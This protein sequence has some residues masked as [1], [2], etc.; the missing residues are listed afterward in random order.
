MKMVNLYEAK[1]HLS[2]L[3]AEIEAGEERIT[4]C[5]NGVPVADLVAH[6]K[7]RGSSML[8][9]ELT[10]AHFLG[11]PCEPLTKSDWPEALR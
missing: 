6:D 3:V 8:D 10:G 7:A 9:P 1:T 2:K 5:R 11:D 4:L